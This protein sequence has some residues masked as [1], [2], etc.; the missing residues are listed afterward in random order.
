M[1]LKPVQIHAGGIVW[2]GRYI[3]V[4]GTARGLYTFAIDDLVRLPNVG[5][6]SFGYRY[7]LPVRFKYVAMTDD[8]FERI[9][10]SF[11]SL[12]RSGDAHQLV[13]G[14]YGRL[15]Q[16]TRLIRYGMDPATGLVETDQ[17]GI[18]R[19]IGLEVDG[20]DQMQGVASVRGQLYVTQSQG[21]LRRGNL[22]VGAPGA[23]TVHERALPQ[24][25]EDICYWPSTD[26]LWSVSEHPP[27]RYV[28][29]MDRPG[30]TSVCSR[31]AGAVGCAGELPR[32]GDQPTG[33]VPHVSV[34]L[35]H[36]A[37][38]VARGVAHQQPSRL[39][40]RTHVRGELEGRHPAEVPEVERDRR[41]H[42]DGVSSMI[43]SGSRP[44]GSR[45]QPCVT[46][47]PDGSPR[48]Q[49]VV[50]GSRRRST[51]SMN[52]PAALKLFG[53]AALEMHSSGGGRSGIT[54]VL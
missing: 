29:A 41:Q 34:L 11:L 9:R 33:R 24:G 16:S 8:G 42:V 10:Y 27:L 54:A 48:A 18:S 50:A 1:T 35:E 14:E 22:L 21:R 30:S 6:E 40:L 49:P 44:S 5:F 36:P 7:V 37:R 2:H 32:L 31:A 26:Q 51:R 43:G 4:A 47:S 13:A 23:F 46:S 12:D 39:R 45:N 28:F 20:V 38:V 52:G 19:P 3:H 15:G 25:P 17:E 53:I